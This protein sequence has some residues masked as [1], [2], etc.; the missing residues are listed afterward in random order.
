MPP[1]VLRILVAICLITSAC[2]AQPDRPSVSDQTLVVLWRDADLA[3]ESQ[4]RPT[5]LMEALEARTTWVSRL[6]P[7]MSVVEVPQGAAELAHEVLVH[8]RDIESELLDGIMYPAVV[9]NDPHWT[10]TSPVQFQQY[11]AWKVCLENG[12]D[13]QRTSS[14][15]TAVLDTGVRYSYTDISPNLLVNTIEA[16]GVMEKDDDNNGIKDDIYG[17][18]YLI[19]GDPY[20]TSP[21]SAPHSDPFDLV[22]HGTF[23]GSIVGA[24]GDNSNHM[25]GVVWNGP[26]L[27]VKVIGQNGGFG[28]N[29]AKS[30]EY[31]YVR[32]A[33]VMNMSIAGTYSP[34]QSSAI[35]EAIRLVMLATPSALYVVAAG[36]SNMDL[37]N[38]SGPGLDWYPA[39]FGPANMI[40]VGASNSDDGRASFSNYGSISVDVF[41]PGVGIV[42]LTIGESAVADDGTSFATPIVAGLA[43]LRWPQ[44]PTLSPTQI[45]DKIKNGGDIISALSGLC[46]GQG[47]GACVR[48]NPATTLGAVCP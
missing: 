45:V 5:P 30:M 21:L 6:V 44:D 13:Q 23:V 42:G 29:I 7:G 26:V 15:I 4:E 16:N 34:G 25:T 39:E 18:E 33:R 19:D 43:S 20:E 35:F 1:N 28:S 8:D 10:A 12:W 31:A 40:V 32:G 48:V 22:L 24:R 38:T 27:H 14:I 2:F 47:S 3:N 36:N 41:A 17:A 46:F 9:P 11:G 37:D